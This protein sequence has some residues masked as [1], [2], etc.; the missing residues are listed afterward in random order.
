MMG[1]ID[2]AFVARGDYI[3]REGDEAANPITLTL[4]LTLS[5][6]LSLTLTLTLALTRPAQGRWARRL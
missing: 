3:I 1:L 6:S 5:L 4:S 2:K